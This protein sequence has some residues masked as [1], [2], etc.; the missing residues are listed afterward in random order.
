MA[1]VRDR[2]PYDRWSH[3]PPRAPVGKLDAPY[4]THDHVILLTARIADFAAK[5]Q[6]RKVQATEAA[7]SRSKPAHDFPP[8]L[9]DQSPSFHSSTWSPSSS[10]SLGGKLATTSAIPPPSQI[11]MYGM[12]PSTG[13]L[14]P[15]AGFDPEPP[16]GPYRV[17]PAQGLEAALL[18]A[19]HE[20]NS[21]CAAL[22]TFEESLGP[23]YQ[24]LSPD[25]MQPLSTPFGP[26]LY[27]R[28]YSVACIWVLFYTARI[29]A[30]R[31]QPS[32]PPAA[33]IAAGVAAPRTAGWANS[34]GRIC[35]GIQ[36]SPNGM[37][38]NPS[39]GSAMMDSCMGLFHAG[40]QYRDA[41]Q[42]AWTITKLREVARLTGWQLSALIASGCERSWIKAAETGKGP[43]YQGTMNQMAKDD[44]VAGR[45]RD[46]TRQL[47]P[48]KDNNDRR[49][50]VV[51]PGA[52]VYWAMGILS[53]E[54][55]M[56]ALSLND[57]FRHVN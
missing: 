52:R 57:W 7:R 17:S 54:E 4:G 56:K 36:P 38:M 13:P 33:M 1:N 34:I 40:V 44:R 51:N 12:M 30:M 35:A 3:C 10:R 25:H 6:R 22:D 27:Y 48:P 47:C 24:A 14:R 41:A 42:R 9:S 32:M 49:L 15:P 46:P 28:S 23:D 18:E 45:Y 16:E 21:I 5:D 19:E 55:D 43:P 50:V 11:P 8:A 20:W 26:A 2:L 39:L 37:P 31:A 53:V 29:M